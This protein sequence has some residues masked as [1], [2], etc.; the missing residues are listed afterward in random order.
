MNDI[1]YSEPDNGWS[2]DGSDTDDLADY[3]QNE[4]SDYSGE[5]QYSS[6]DE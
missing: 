3:N 4:V 1:L 5:D 6:I 2:G